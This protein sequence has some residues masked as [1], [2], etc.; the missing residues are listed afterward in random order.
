V[1]S[2]EEHIATTNA[3]GFAVLN[4][5]NTS[6]KNFTLKVNGP[7]GGSFIQ[8]MVQ[9]TNFETKS[10]A[11]LINVNLEKGVSLSG[12]ITANGSPVVGAKVL[13]EMGPSTTPIFTFSDDAGKYSLTGF[14]TAADKSAV[15]KVIAPEI[16]PNN[17]IGT[18]AKVVFTNSSTKKDF[19]LQAFTGF[20]V[21]NF[22]GFK[23]EITTLRVINADEVEVSGF[24][25]LNEMSNSFALAEN[26]KPTFSKLIIKKG[27]RANANGIIEGIPQKTELATNLGTLKLKYGKH[28]NTIL[29]G[30]QTYQGKTL[31]VKKEDN[32]TGI[33]GRVYIVDNSFDFPGSYLSFGK[34]NFY[35]ADANLNNASKLIVAPFS[36]D[37]KVQG[38]KSIYNL[39]NSKG[40]ALEFNFLQF[41]AKANPKTSTITL[42]PN[43]EPRLAMDTEIR[44]NFENMNPSDLKIEL[45]IFEMNHEKIFPLTG[46]QK[47][48]FKLEQWDVEVNNW[49]LTANKGGIFSNDGFVNTGVVQVPF[50]YFHMQ[51]N[52]LKFDQ[53]TLSNLSLGGVTP[54][55]V[56]AGVSTIFGFDKATGTDKKPHW[57]LSL[58]GNA[59][60]PAAQFGGMEGLAPGKKIGI[61][62]LS[63]ISNGEQLLS[64]GAATTPIILYDVIKFTPSTIT[65]YSDYYT[66]GGK[67]DLGIPRINSNLTGNL[68][69]KGKNGGKI[70]L[71]PQQ[72]EFEGKGFVKFQTNGNGDQKQTLSKGKLVL[73][74]TIEEP[75]KTP[76]FKCEMVKNGLNSVPGIT[77]LPN[78]TVSLGSNKLT[79]VAGNMPVKNNDWDYFSFEGDLTGF[80]GV[81]QEKKR[82]K[83]TVYGDIKAEGQSVKMDNINTPFGG[84]E[85][86]Y[87]YNNNRLMG[88]MD[89]AMDF[90]ESLS[91]L[92]VANMLFDNQGFY[93]SAAAQVTAPVV[94]TFNAGILVGAYGKMPA[95]VLNDVVKFNYNK[96]VP[97][98]LSTNGLKGFFI[99]GGRELPLQVPNFSID[100]PPGL[101]LVSV[102]A[103]ATSG[104]EVQ[105]GMD[106]KKGTIL[107]AQAL[108]YAK[109]WA[110]IGSISCTEASANAAAEIMVTG[111]YNAGTFNIDGCGSL[112]LDVKGSQRVPLLV[113]CVAPEISLNTTLGAKYLI[114]LGSD[115]FY[116][117]VKFSLGSD[118][119]NCT[120]KINCN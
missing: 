31:S 2:I 105:L 52:L 120:A 56:N 36:T 99:T 55:E 83:F 46:K 97:C 102:N 86:V 89:I 87:D 66:L 16:N 60:K 32:V 70:E 21:N 90:S 7:N 107:T 93:I 98:Y 85:L 77:L 114:H 15:V 79:K 73:L 10:E 40:E 53:F 110:G 115:G 118:A 82:M 74:G 11:S 51:N 38:P 68:V 25:N 14:Q 49:Q 88:H 44:A 81:S 50:K 95:N 19:A 64:F 9:I 109:A 12:T 23:L 100:I 22:F 75:G 92:G 17:L 61:E 84:M 33:W 67:L 101:A 35:F 96:Q 54:L 41:K 111:T 47:I 28:I 80:E 3:E 42:M 1:V 18:E 119:S 108:I 4:F 71:L 103:G 106:F 57:K 34:T 113:D 91:V 29:S 43:G 63:L 58:V 27:S 6:T 112:L 48:K 104:L 13:V 24:I 30:Q 72:F 26:A 116:Q 65:S 78:Q 69:V 94:N 62:V 76:Q 39:C 59:S 20:E 37:S 45:G 5:A 117:K 8:K